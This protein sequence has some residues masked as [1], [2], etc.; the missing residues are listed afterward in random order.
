M[1]SPLSLGHWSFLEPWNL[2]FELFLAFRF[3]I[4][5]QNSTSFQEFPA[6]P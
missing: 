3:S 1:G 6:R 4:R 5:M 2:G